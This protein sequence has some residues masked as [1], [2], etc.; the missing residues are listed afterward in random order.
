MKKLVLGA[1]LAAIAFLFIAAGFPRFPIFD[2]VLQ[3]DLDANQKSITNAL[4]F[5]GAP[6][7]DGSHL[8][9]VTA[10]ASGAAGGVLSGTYPNPGFGTFSSATLA[11]ALTDENGGGPALFSTGDG[12]GLTK[13]NLASITNEPANTLVGNPTGAS[14]AAQAFGW[15]ATLSIVGGKLSVVGGGG[16]GGVT[17]NQVLPSSA[18]VTNASSGIVLL[19]TGTNL[20]VE[21]FYTNSSGAYLTNFITVGGAASTNGFNVQNALNQIVLQSTTNGQ[22]Y[23]GTNQQLFLDTS[24]NLTLKGALTATGA[25]LSGLTATSIIGT[26]G[27]KNLKSVLL[28]GLTYDGTTLTSTAGGSGTGIQTNNGTGTNNLLTG[29]LLTNALTAGAFTRAM[30]NLNGTNGVRTLINAADFGLTTSGDNTTP[31]NNAIAAAT[32]QGSQNNT[33]VVFIPAGQWTVSGTIL[34]TNG[35]V[36]MGETAPSAGAAG[37][38][39][40]LWHS[41]ASVPLIF[42]RSKGGAVK[43]LFLFANSPANGA[44]GIAVETNASPSAVQNCWIDNVTVKNFATGW[45]GS[46]TW[47]WTFLNWYDTGCNIGIY[48]SNACNAFHIIG[49]HSTALAA[50]QIGIYV[51]ARGGNCFDWTVSTTIE[52]MTNGVVITGDSSHTVNSF[53]LLNTY[54]ESLTNCLVANYANSLNI[55][56]G[57]TIT[58]AGSSSTNFV[59]VNC[60]NPSIFGTTFYDPTPGWNFDSTCYGTYVHPGY[61]SPT[62]RSQAAIAAQTWM[63]YGGTNLTLT[64][65]SY[66]GNGSGLTNVVSTVV[67][68]GGFSMNQVASTNVLISSGVLAASSQQTNYTIPLYNGPSGNTLRIYLANTNVW[69]TLSGTNNQDWQR[70]VCLDGVSNSVVSRIDFNVLGAVTNLNFVSFITNGTLKIINLYNL[71]TSGT[72]IL[73]SDA[74]TYSHK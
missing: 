70:T 53:M 22:F 35:A 18:I 52:G 57:N 36:L 67:T 32:L 25:L 24:G 2:G 39:T 50:N 43:D 71:D 37:Q 44:I 59:F 14:A 15:D 6:W 63:H 23:A 72:N 3:T 73:I 34:L 28:S 8:S 62:A 74:G 12:G 13:L 58:G 10:T 26:D 19:P 20:M 61:C 51:D 49:G 1:S 65:G 56:G 48:A 33:P 29:P 9:N 69:A 31:I 42:M 30:P 68:N 40:M 41:T 5:V 64:G 16:G 66:Y 21:F 38:G 7:G 45:A 60:A 55:I 11:T 54:F 46:Y 17:N 47:G 27:S 4:N